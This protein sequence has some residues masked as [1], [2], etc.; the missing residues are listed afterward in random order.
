M[1][2]ERMMEY[3]RLSSIRLEEFKSIIEFYFDFNQKEKVTRL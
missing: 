2:G 1:T 3:E